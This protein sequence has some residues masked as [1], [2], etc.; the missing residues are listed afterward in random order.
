MPN[1]SEMNNTEYCQQRKVFRFSTNYKKL[2]GK[3]NEHFRNKRK[4]LGKSAGTP[5]E[6]TKRRMGHALQR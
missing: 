5:G 3:E 6:D 1:A 2:T 4:R